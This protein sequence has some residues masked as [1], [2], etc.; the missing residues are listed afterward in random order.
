MELDPPPM[1]SRVRLRALVIQAI[2]QRAPWGSVMVRVTLPVFSQSLRLVLR[3][4]IRLLG[5]QPRVLPCA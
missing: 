4:L 3:N 2:C 1:L 5:G